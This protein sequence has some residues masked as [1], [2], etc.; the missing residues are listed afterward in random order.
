MSDTTEKECNICNEV[1]GPEAPNL[2][3]LLV[4]GVWTCRGCLNDVFRRVINHD[5]EYPVLM[6]GE[7]ID[8]GEFSAYVDHDLLETYHQLAPEL[9]IHPYRR[10]YCACGTFIAEIVTPNPTNPLEAVDE[11]PACKKTAC[12][13]CKKPINNK[14]PK[15]CASNHSCKEKIEAAEKEHQ[16]LLDGE[17]C[18]TKYQVCPICRRN[19]QLHSAC[20]HIY[21]QCRGHFCYKCGVR[22]FDD[23]HWGGGIFQCELYPNKL[24]PAQEALELLPPE[25]QQRV[26]RE[27]LLD[28]VSGLRDYVQEDPVVQKNN[29]VW[30]LTE[31]G[32]RIG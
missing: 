31:N 29:A 7:L 8:L 10:V 20:Y 14:D 25:D 19:I 6:N 5:D 2:E 13:A 16:K 30:A 9:S 22:T 24:S 3:L 15:A 18:G 26:I 1:L 27:A 4:N 32:A 21:C 11:C 17:D 23:S 28:V 12:K